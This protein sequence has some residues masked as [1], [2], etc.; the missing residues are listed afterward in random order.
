MLRALLLEDSPQDVEIIRELLIDAGFDLDMDCTALEKE[1]VSLLRSNTYDVILADFKLPGFD[2]FG[3][4]RWAKEICPNVPLI[5]VSGT[6]GEETAVELLKLGAV[7]YVLKDR[8]IRLPYAIKRAL[9]EAKEKETQRQAEEELRVALAKYK[10]LFDC[11]PLGIT[12]SDELGNILET[13]PT[14]EKL[15]GIPQTEQNQRDIDSHEWRIVRL[16]GTPMPPD[17]YASVRALKQQCKV[18]NVEMGIVKPDNMIT[19]ISVTATPVPLEGYG[20]VITYNDITERKRTDEALRILSLRQEAILASVPDIIMEVDNNKIYTWANPAGI[21]FF[22]NDVVGKEASYYFEGEQETYKYTQ[23]LFNGSENIIYVESKQRRIDGKIRLLSWW[24]RVLKDKNDNVTGA[25]STARDITVLKHTEEAMI[26]SEIQY[27]RLFEAARDGVLILNA[28][29]GIIVDSN[30]YLTELLGYSKEEIIGKHLWELGFIKDKAASILNVKELQEK[31]YIAYENLPFET[32]DGKTIYVQFVSNVYQVDGSEV[33]QCNIRDITK[34]KLAEDRQVFIAKILAILNRPNEWQ[35]IID[36]ILQETKLFTEFEA[37]AIRLKEGEDYPYFVANGFPAHFVEEER[38]LCARNLDGEIIYAPDGKPFLECMCGNIISNRIDPSLSFFTYG[39]SFWTNSTTELL[40]TYSEKELQTATRNRC[41]SD[42]YESVALIPLKSGGNAIGLL[43]FNDKRTNRFTL[44]MIEFF[45]KIG[46]TIGIA[47]KRMQAEKQ[48]RES[49]E[50]Y[51]FIVEATNDVIYRLKYDTMMFDYMNPAIEKLTGYSPEE[52]NEIG[53]KSLV[54]KICKYHVENVNIDLVVEDRQKG[55]TGEWQAD[56]Q[57]RTK[58]GKLIWLSDHS[59]PWNDEAGNLIGS[60]GIL[61]DIT[62]RKLAEDEIINAKEKAEEMNRL[63]SSFLANMSHE[64]RTPLIGILG[65]AEILQTQLDDVELKEQASIIF[66][67]GT[68]LKDTLNLILDLSKIEA[69]S[70]AVNLEEIELTSYIPNLVKVFE[71]SA[72]AKG[73]ELKV[74]TGEELLF[75]NLDKVLLD[76]I[77]NNLVNNAIKYTHQGKVTVEINKIID[78]EKL[79]AELLVADSGIGIEEENLVI[80]FEPFRQASEGWGRS[81]EGTGLG[82]TLVK[83]YV[84]SLKGTISVESKVGVGSTFKVRFPITKSEFR[85]SEKADI[86]TKEGNYVIETERNNK[87]LILYVEDDIVSQQVIKAMVSN[88]YRIEYIDE[89]EAAVELVKQKKYDIILMDINLKGKLN[90][91]ETAKEIKKIEGYESISII[92]VTA[93]AMAGDKEKLL[94]G[95]CTHYIS[96][97]FSKDEFL[98]LLSEGL[99]H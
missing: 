88:F 92:A 37:I 66:D 22:G 86:G 6:I 14:A 27:R 57:L 1:F 99:N 45:E 76:S 17:E 53:L 46:S 23:P 49:E 72:E 34:R 9:V 85:K 3:A 60:I 82:L 94:S 47:F 84:E 77:N 59:F 19:W 93:Y 71:K 74:I 44:E 18:E 87:P 5:F 69:E 32:I 51:R 50:R 95:G 13:N 35:Q 30:P 2:G 64:L 63:K 21:E 40:S 79:Y 10:T 73:I 80:I 11:L 81:Y 33:I 15:L 83:K 91:L 96:K 75:S 20:V 61:I 42:G 97:P 31:K 58:A 65:Y 98:S 29:T 62:E 55:M 36:D 4:L 67:S 56:Y 12:V 39:G 41:N 7:D 89:G 24:C 52:I 28:Q 16:D 48:I 54:V 43:Q 78:K 25:L 26:K 38:F 68:R 90:G 70:L 8:P